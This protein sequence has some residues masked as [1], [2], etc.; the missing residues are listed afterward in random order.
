MIGTSKNVWQ[1]EIDASCELI[2]FWR[3][4]AYYAEQLYKMQPIIHDN[5]IW[6]SFEHRPLEG[7]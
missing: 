4:S 7:I 6:N 2:D 5:G 3:F 1:A